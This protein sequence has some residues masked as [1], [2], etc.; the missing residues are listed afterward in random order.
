MVPVARAFER[1]IKALVRCVSGMLV[2]TATGSRFRTSSSA[3]CDG[4][5]LG[6]EPV[7]PPGT[8]QVLAL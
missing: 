3:L 1:I 8:W 2:A 6:P 7:F 5:D 4:L